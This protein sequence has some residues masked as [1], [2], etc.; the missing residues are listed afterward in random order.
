[1]AFNITSW[2]KGG[3]DFGR[4][5]PPPP[6]SIEYIAVGDMWDPEICARKLREEGRARSRSGFDLKFYEISFGDLDAE[7]N[8]VAS[9]DRAV[10]QARKVHGDAVLS[11]E[12]ERSWDNFMSRWRPFAADMRLVPGSPS[13]MLKQNKQSFD[14]LA[15]EA[16][17]LHDKFVRKGMSEVPVPYAGELLLLLRQMPKKLTA[18][19]M[20]AKLLA[21]ARCGER[22]LDANTTWFDWVASRDHHPLRDAV[23]DAGRAADIYGRSRSSAATYSPGDPA[24]DEFLRRLTKIWVEASGLYGIR[25]TEATA[26]AHL[27]DDLSEKSVLYFAGLLAAAGAAYLGVAWLMRPSRPAAV[28]VP[29]AYPER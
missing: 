9:V 29:D 5:A 21:G 6:G 27:K 24:Y 13:M 19:Q 8:Y 15:R 26:K 17:S 10:K 11:R 12:D 14:L 16:S 4:G 1:M 28:G 22:L 2:G 18:S 3:R 23:A 7:E 25:E 20:S